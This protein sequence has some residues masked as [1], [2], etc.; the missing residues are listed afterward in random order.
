LTE[1]EMGRMAAATVDLAARVTDKSDGN[2]SVVV[3][4]DNLAGH[5]FPSGVGFRRAFLEVTALDA[6]GNALWA[7]GATNAAGVI[8]GSNGEPLPGE[9]TKDWRELQP[10]Y[11]LIDSE[12]QALIFESR[13]INTEGELTTSFLGLAK[14]VK[15]NRLLPRGWTADG[16]YA[17]ETQLVG[18]G[19]EP[20]NPAEPGRRTVT[21]TIPA[22]AG[23]IDAVRVRLR[24]Q[25]TPPYYLKDRF[26]VAG[27][28]SDR[29]KYLASFVN[30]EGTLAEDWAV[31]VATAIAR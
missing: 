22:A 28:E 7:S 5:K 24:Y 9:F 25:S 23:T 26:A 12:D 6:A 2:W 18:L 14:E 21:Y 29:L 19:G 3:Q 17:D 8:L 11:T 31:N 1:Q 13:H 4:I 15:D 10:D 30:L 27:P 20:V 16:P